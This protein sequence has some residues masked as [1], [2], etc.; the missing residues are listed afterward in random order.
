MTRSFAAT[1]V[2]LLAVGLGACATLPPTP[3][4]PPSSEEGSTEAQAAWA[5]V[6]RGVLPCADCEGIE[7][8]VTLFPEHRYRS[9]TRYL[10]GTSGAQ[11]AEGAVAWNADRTIVSLSGE[12]PARYRVEGDRLVALALDG[13]PVTGPLSNRYVL[14]RQTVDIAETYWKLVEL[15]GKPVSGLAGE[16]YLLLKRDG[17]R[18]N[19][20][21][22]CNNFTGTY[23]VDAD[24]ARI[25]LGQLASTSRACMSGMDVEAAFHAVLERADNYSLGEGRLTLNRARMAPLARFEAVWLR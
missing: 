13:S 24:H 20:F 16:P 22:G 17:K 9:E 7:T 21:G 19:G 8:V 18:V 4:V 1:S 12:K 5:G 14:A 6:Y 25:R 15:N 10:G 3:D 23:S 2:F 11:L